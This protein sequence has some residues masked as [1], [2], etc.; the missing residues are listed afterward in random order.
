MLRFPLYRL[1]LIFITMLPV[2]SNGQELNY[3]SL[4]QRIDTVENPVF[5]PVVS[6][7]YGILNFRGDVRSSLITPLTGSGAAMINVAT[8]IDRKNRYYIANFNFF[9]GTLNANEFSYTN[10]ERNLNF[11][12]SLFAIGG[13]IEYRFGH[14]I[15]NHAFLRPYVNVGLES[16]NFSSKGDLED[17]NGNSYYYWSDGTIRDQSESMGDANVLY[18]D[19]DYETDLRLKEESEYGLGKYSQR[20]IGFPLGAGIH[21][22]ISERAS[23][24]LGATYHLTLTDYMDNVAYEGTSVKGKKGNDAFVFSHISLHFDL[25]SDPSTRTVDLLYADAEFD[26]LFFDDEDGDFILDV[27]DHCPGTPYGIEVD[28]LGCPLDGDMDGVPDY[29]DM[30]LAT[31]PGAWVNDEGVTL[32]ENDFYRQ[33]EARNNA[34]ARGEVEHYFSSIADLYIVESSGEIPEKFQSLDEDGDGY[35]SFDELL[36]TIDLYFDYQLELNIEEVKELNNFF[37]SQ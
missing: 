4:L 37:F 22:M 20:S 23:F 10:P 15:P 9:T 11:E 29:L 24:S 7:S 1:L 30:E 2:L 3:D 34:M 31:A 32:T 33:I 28:S 6:F 8:F 27:S 17:V 16:I 36:K 18:R 12:T 35:I 5:K 14:I 25:F 13:N 19:Y 26:P 21:F